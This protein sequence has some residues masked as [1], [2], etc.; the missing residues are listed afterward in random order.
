MNPFRK[1][2]GKAHSA[3][4]KAA[5]PLVVIDE[6]RKKLMLLVG[7]HEYERQVRNAQIIVMSQRL[8]ELDHEREL[9]TEKAAQDK[10]EA[11]RLAEGK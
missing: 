5:R 1:T 2:E 10:A 9:A 8:Q 3:A 11:E 6:E 4:V 7:S